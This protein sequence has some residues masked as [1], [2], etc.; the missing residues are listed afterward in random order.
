MR[1]QNFDAMHWTYKLEREKIYF[2][3]FFMKTNRTPLVF[4][5]VFFTGNSKS[6]NQ[7]ALIYTE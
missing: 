4:V 5:V 3:F 1:G 7:L 6:Q 2:S